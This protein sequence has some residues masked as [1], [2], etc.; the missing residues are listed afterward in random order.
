MG[1]SRKWKR[2]VNF[3]TIQGFHE[4]IEILFVAVLLFYSETRA[5]HRS[6]RYCNCVSAPFPLLG[7]S[8]ETFPFLNTFNA[9]VMDRI[10]SAIIANADEIS[11]IVESY[12]REEMSSLSKAK[13]QCPVLRQTS[14]KTTLLMT[15]F[16]GVYGVIIVGWSIAIF[17]IQCGP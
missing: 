8:L 3:C 10:N 17:S 7:T 15:N 12:R 9:S 13:M 1:S 11:T 6:N 4:L 5:H 16:I 14:T 2:F